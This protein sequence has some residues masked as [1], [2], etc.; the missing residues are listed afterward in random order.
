MGWSEKSGRRERNPMIKPLC[1]VALCAV[2]V[3]AQETG[4]RLTRGV[5]DVAVSGGVQWEQHRRVAPE[6]VNSFGL[7]YSAGITRHLA[8][9]ADYALD[10][11]GNVGAIRVR[12]H[13]FAG[14]ARLQVPVGGTVTP[15]VIGLLGGYRETA[16][17]EGG[18]LDVGASLTR[19]VYGGGAGIEVRL[20]KW[21]GFRT[22]AR[23]M[24]SDAPWYGRVMVGLYL[25][26]R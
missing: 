20:T 8:G 3:L 9:V 22:E 17:L 24:G 16:R 26:H 18:G 12:G 5:G 6:V 2:A 23:A 25:R 19:F 10:W 1:F 15:Y 11:Y 13:E 21:A 7:R 4:G 14:G